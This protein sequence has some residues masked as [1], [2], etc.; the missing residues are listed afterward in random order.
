MCC[1]FVNCDS[2]FS[3]LLKIVFYSIEINILMAVS[4]AK[5]DK[6]LTL[7]DFFA[8]FIKK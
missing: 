7:Q 8:S 5:I 4:S 6:K 1:V 2:N 3:A